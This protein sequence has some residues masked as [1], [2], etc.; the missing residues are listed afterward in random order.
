MPATLDE[1][2]A[3]IIELQKAVSDI[4]DSVRKIRRRMLMASIYN[5]IKFI[6]V[7]GT[8]VFGWVYVQPYMNDLID[9][10]Q[11]MSAQLK[12]MKQAPGVNLNDPAVQDAIRQYMLHNR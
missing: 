4:G 12:A 10:W 7:I 5:T 2:K 3:E 6:I 8:L 1:L 9:Q 11:T